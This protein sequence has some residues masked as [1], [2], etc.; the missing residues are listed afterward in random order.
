MTDAPQ[1]EQPRLLESPW[2]GVRPLLPL[3]AMAPSELSAERI[4][5]EGR[6]PARSPLVVAPLFACL[7]CVPWLAQG[8]LTWQRVLTFAVLLSVAVGLAALGWPRSRRVQV[9]PR[10]GH[11]VGAGVER[12]L[13]ASAR[14]VLEIQPEPADPGAY[15]YA[16]ALELGEE[17]WWLLQGRDPARVLADLSRVLRVWQL[18]VTVGWGLPDEARP[19]EFRHAS[20]LDT[21]MRSSVRRRQT[22]SEGDP[23]QV[24]RGLRPGARSGLASVLV[25]ISV[26]IAADMI[27]LVASGSRALA[28]VHPLS[29][30]LP[31]L[32]VLGLVLLTVVVASV[33]EAIVVGPEVVLQRSSLLFGSE[34]GRVGARSVRAVH[35]VGAEQAKEHHVLIESDEGPLAMAVA[36]EEARRTAQELARAVDAPR[37]HVQRAAYA[38]AVPELRHDARETSL[39]R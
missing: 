36:A 16:A 35:V 2:Q 11:L 26:T 23:L 7:A 21:S 22:T 30:A 39:G 19:W 9:S 32:M 15:R 8:P 31:T 38:A 3:A 28:F 18:P 12:P 1:S 25:L 27:F 6:Q 5:F 10:H 34:R 29:V 4:V 20:E 13:G 33:H 24:V 14:W 37:G 17:R